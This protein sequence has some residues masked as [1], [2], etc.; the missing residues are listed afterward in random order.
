MLKHTLKIIK[1]AKLL[2][3]RANHRDFTSF[4]ID[5]EPTK[6]FE[7]SKI[8]TNFVEQ[9]VAKFEEVNELPKEFK[10]SFIANKVGGS[11]F[12][13]PKDNHKSNRGR[14]DMFSR[15]RD[16]RNDRQGGSRDRN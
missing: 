16:R 7:T 11:D 13:D 5:L 14:N 12:R 8:F 3:F 1:K 6:D 2:H 4:L 15:G 9:G 10:E